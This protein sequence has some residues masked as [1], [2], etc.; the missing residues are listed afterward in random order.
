MPKTS[1]NPGTYRHFPVD[2]AGH[3]SNPSGP[4]KALLEWSA[5][6]PE[7]LDSGADRPKTELGPA[8]GSISLRH[9]RHGWVQEA[10]IRVLEQHASPMRARDVHLAVEARLGSPV[11]WASVK[12]CLAANVRGES[13]Q[14]V[15]VAYGCYALRRPT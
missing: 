10:V 8:M 5:Q 11:R 12:A 13:S 7:T 4:L 9:R 2:L 14:F 15:R 3:H 1:Q 6:A